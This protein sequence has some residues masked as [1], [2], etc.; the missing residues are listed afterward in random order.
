MTRESPRASTGRSR[1]EVGA[2]E[3][4]VPQ[5]VEGVTVET[6]REQWLVEDQWWTP[7]PLSRRYFDL[8]LAGGR[9]TVV[10]CE[11]FPGGRWYSQRS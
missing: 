10:F 2:D 1:L 11:P 5:E 3:D 6:I 9:C 4:G 7:R 8:V